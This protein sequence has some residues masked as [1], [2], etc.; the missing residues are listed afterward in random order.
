LDAAGNTVSD[1]QGKR[2]FEYNQRGQLYKVYYNNK[3]T[4]V[5]I[6]N[7]LGQRTRK[8]IQG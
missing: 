6:Y 1:Q 4:A 2:R 7:A 3:L 5:Y 8:D